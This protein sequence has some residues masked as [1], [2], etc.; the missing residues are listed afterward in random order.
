MAV[1]ALAVAERVLVGVGG[2]GVAQAAEAMVVEVM[3]EAA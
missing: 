2:V 1:V 3:A